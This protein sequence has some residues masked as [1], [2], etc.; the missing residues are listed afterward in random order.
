MNHSKLQLDF[1]FDCNPIIN[2]KLNTKS[3]KKQRSDFVFDT[4]DCL[5][6]PVIVFKS[7]W[8]DA[9]PTDILKNVTIS[10]MMTL[11][12]GE[13][14][15]SI[16]EVVAYMMPRTFESPMPSEWVNIYTWSGLQYASMFKDRNQRKEMMKAMEDIAPETLSEYE[17]G[18]LKHLRCWIYEKRRKALKESLKSE[19]QVKSNGIITKQNHLFDH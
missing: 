8:Q 11:I 5:T 9:I 2:Q 19:K 12:S 15:A 18:L 3:N 1:G 6:S 13:Q 4:M 17:Q 10:R 14:M 16:T 7:A